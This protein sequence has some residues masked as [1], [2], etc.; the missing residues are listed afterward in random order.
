MNLSQ[1]FLENIL[2]LA[3]TATLT[4]F[5]IPY[6]FKR[7]DQRKLRE[8][9]EF[10]AEIA[11]QAKIIE[12]Q[13]HLLEDM[14]QYLWEYQLAAIEVSYYDPTGQ[15]KLYAS[16]VEKY[17]EKIG[18]LL[19]KIR[20]EISKALRLTSP[21][22]YQEFKELYYQHLLPLD[23]KLNSLIKAQKIGAEKVNGWHEF[24]EFA[25]FTLSEM[26]D[27]ALNNLAKE[28]RLKGG[29]VKPKLKSETIKVG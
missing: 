26:V 3:T 13:V 17:H 11:L 4:G 16:A 6:I 23:V 5:L 27:N 7:I 28:L 19:S 8:Q 12:S 1:G 20:A 2:T 24:N 14:A 29:N 9:K 10:E 21:Q 22:T 15:Q 18:P 25:V